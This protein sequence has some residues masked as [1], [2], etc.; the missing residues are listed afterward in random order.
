[1]RITQPSI[2]N[3]ETGILNICSEFTSE[4]ESQ[5]DRITFNENTPN[6]HKELVSCSSQLKKSTKLDEIPHRKWGV[7]DEDAQIA[8]YS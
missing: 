7:E 6:I 1:M 2:L 8:Y 4:P 3:P 5:K